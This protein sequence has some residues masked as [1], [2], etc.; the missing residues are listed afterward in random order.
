MKAIGHPEYRDW[1]NPC[2]PGH[3]DC[4]S[5]RPFS[6]YSNAVTLIGF[7]PPST[8]EFFSSSFGGALV[9]LFPTNAD[10]AVVK[11]ITEVLTLWFTVSTIMFHTNNECCRTFQVSIR[12]LI[13][14]TSLLLSR[15]Y[16]GSS[17]FYFRLITQNFVDAFFLVLLLVC[18]SVSTSFEK[19]VKPRFSHF[20]FDE[21]SIVCLKINN[22]TFMTHF[23]KKEICEN[24]IFRFDEFFVKS[25]YDFQ[26]LGIWWSHWE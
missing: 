17:S 20:H 13:L 6:Q 26:D 16:N 10:R 4:Q 14:H 15:N 22:N 24:K 21:M 9:A 8:S 12:W 23:D 3:F 1:K 11:S 19:F 2:H 7:L 18:K 25:K 5:C